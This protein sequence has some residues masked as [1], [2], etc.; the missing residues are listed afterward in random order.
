MNPGYEDRGSGPERG[1][2][3]G[4]GCGTRHRTRLQ[5]LREATGKSPDELA[6]LIG[7]SGSVYYD[8]EWH[9]DDLVL[10]ASLAELARLSS[11]LGVPT[12]AIFEGT[13][14]KEAAISR[15]YLS[16]RVRAHLGAKRMPLS[17]FED[18]VGYDIGRALEDPAEVLSWNIDCLRSV[19]AEIGLNW[20]DALP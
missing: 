15:E 13:G 16:D 2:G 3:A 6:R 10:T 14:G 4:E 18:K 9:E 12:R 5:R 17:E 19:C 7:I 8:W 20:L 1:S 11:V